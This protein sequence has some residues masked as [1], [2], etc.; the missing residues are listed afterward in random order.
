MDL[1]FATGE[2][3]P[4]EQLAAW[5]DL[6]NRVFLPLAITPLR[7]G[8]RPGE[9]DG[10]VTGSDWGGVRV[11]RVRASPM[12]AVR[13]QHHI[14]SSASDDYLLALHVSGTAHA[15]Q[16]GRQVT[17]GPG[18][19]ALFDSTRPYSIEFSGAGTFEHLI[20]QVPR[21]SL[22]ARRQIANATALRV[23]AASSAGQLVSPYLRTLARPASAPGHA[24]AQGFIDAGLDLAV[25]ALLT[26]AGFHG[27]LDSR[28]RSLAGEL[29]RYALAHLGD[30]SLTPEAVARASYI[31]VRQLHRFFA[32]EGVSFSAWV[33]EERLRRCR[34]DLA[35]QHLSHRAVSEIATRWGFGSAA[36]F[37]RA[38]H[39][40]YGITPTGLRRASRHPHD[41]R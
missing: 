21:A 19:F 2:V 32:G 20:Y 9:F 7:A 30:A 8:S 40:R 38:F 16:D 26:V 33:R 25:S 29:K 5:R 10:S 28:R 14:K 37:T 31:S 4:P 18:D 39:A 23:R 3:E 17:L 15:A 22:D 13:A 24:P 6:V 27:H 35:D 36:H 1:A 41:A 34:D 12:S 11:W